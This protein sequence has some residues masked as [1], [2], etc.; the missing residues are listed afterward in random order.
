MEAELKALYENTLATLRVA[1]LKMYVPIGPGG[2]AIPAYGSQLF[3]EYIN[4][5]ELIDKYEEL[6]SPA[7]EKRSHHEQW[8]FE[9]YN[10]RG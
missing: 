1:K 6:L 5:C 4:L 9:F 2:E 8:V 3:C 10:R 7:R